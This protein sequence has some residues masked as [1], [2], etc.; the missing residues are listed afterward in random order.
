MVKIS[1]VMNKGEETGQEI[2]ISFFVFFFCQARMKV[3]TSN[4]NRV[5][6]D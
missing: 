3:Y 5:S 2:C 1:V 6:Q 4:G